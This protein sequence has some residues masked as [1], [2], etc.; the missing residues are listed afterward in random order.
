MLR[1][2]KNRTPSEQFQAYVMHSK[3]DGG[4]CDVNI[5][6]PKNLHNVK[7]DLKLP[8]PALM[9][10]AAFC[11]DNKSK[12]DR[13][14]A[15]I[16]HKLLPDVPDVVVHFYMAFTRYGKFF[17]IAWITVGASLV[18]LRGNSEELFQ[19]VAV[20]IGTDSEERPRTGIQGHAEA[21]VRG[22]LQATQICWAA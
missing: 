14:T 22:A 8:K 17:L 9:E 4:K 3:L 18:F 11:E 16:R 12:L 21:L 15:V 6:V 20:G 5:E 2:D 1:Y 13:F 10:A 19:M 7:L